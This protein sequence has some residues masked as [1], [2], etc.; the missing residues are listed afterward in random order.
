MSPTL[1]AELGFEDGSNTVGDLD[2]GMIL[3]GTHNNNLFIPE[4]MPFAML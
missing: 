4:L 1:G 3:K 2:C